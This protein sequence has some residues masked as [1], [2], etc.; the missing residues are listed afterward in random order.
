MT[1]LKAEFLELNRPGVK[2][3]EEM[4]LFAGNGDP[5]MSR[6]HANAANVASFDE[7]FFWPTSVNLYE[8]K[9]Q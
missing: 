8:R 1:N 5:K 7:I 4:R 6:S 2:Y 9:E 3:D